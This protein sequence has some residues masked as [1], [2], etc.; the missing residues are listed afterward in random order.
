[1]K[2]L[3]LIILISI[4]LFLTCSLFY[5]NLWGYNECQKVEGNWILLNGGRHCVDK[6]FIEIDI[7]SNKP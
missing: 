2:H 3:L 1:M 5:A 4:I 6:D 7:Y